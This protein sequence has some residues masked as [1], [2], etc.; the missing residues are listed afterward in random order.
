VISNNATSFFKLVTGQ[1]RRVSAVMYT[2]AAAFVLYF[3]LAFLHV[4]FGI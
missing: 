4:N 2:V 3:S 1:A